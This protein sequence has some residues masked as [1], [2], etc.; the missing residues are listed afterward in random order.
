[1]EE[2]LAFNDGY[3]FIENVSAKDKIILKTMKLDFPAN[4]LTAIMGPSGSGKTTLLSVITDSIQVNISARGEIHLPGQSA[5]VPQDDR[6][7]GF[8]TCQQYLQHYARLAGIAH[9]PETKERIEKLLAQMGL[10]DQAN[11]VVGDVFF[12]GLSGGQ[13]RRSVS[14]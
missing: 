1:M 6:L 11:T 8:Y 10:T 7:H 14:P 5:F 3:V 12:K 2:P 4:A 9:K 13:Q